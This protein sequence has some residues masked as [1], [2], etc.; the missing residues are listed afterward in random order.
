MPA[1][2]QLSAPAHA[3]PLRQHG[4]PCPPQLVHTLAGSAHL[5]PVPQTLPPQHRLLSVPHSTHVVAGSHVSDIEA[6]VAKAQQLSLPEPHRSQVALR[7][8]APAR[9]ASPAQHGPPGVPH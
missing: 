6:Q 7:Q 9:H 1:A 3:V 8:L 4:S 2:L 5:I